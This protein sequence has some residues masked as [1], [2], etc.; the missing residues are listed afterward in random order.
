LTLDNL[1]K[2]GFRYGLDHELCDPVASAY[3][4]R[5]HR[6]GV[7]EQDPE[8][9]AVATIDQPRG[10]EARHAVTEGETAAWQ[11]E[12][13]IAMG[14]RDGDSGGDKRTSAT[15]HEDSILTGVQI[16]PGVAR[17][18]VARHRQIGIE[19]DERDLQHHETLSPE[20]Q[21]VLGPSG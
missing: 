14:K 6:I 9:V 19:A 1:G 7:D 5:T 11:D 16:C 2:G 13:G 17:M 18:R 12:P 4:I 3:L 20:S 21:R 10:V 8:L 15:G